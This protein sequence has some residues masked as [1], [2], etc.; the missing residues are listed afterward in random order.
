MGCRPLPTLPRI[1]YF[2]QMYGYNYK[3]ALVHFFVYLKYKK[4]NS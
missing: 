2:L 4:I 3:E 1:L